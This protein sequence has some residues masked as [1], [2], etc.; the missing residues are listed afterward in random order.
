M[1]HI[2]TCQISKFCQLVFR[3]E[4]HDYETKRN[5][6]KLELVIPAMVDEEERERLRDLAVDAC[7]ALGVEVVGRVEIL[8]DRNTRELFVNE[9]NAAPAFQPAAPFAR[10]WEASGLSPERVVERLAS[11]CDARVRDRFRN[12]VAPGV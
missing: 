8:R 10:L 1:R 3:S 5:A 11:A 6:D 12:Q 9:V 2:F 4:F 7:A